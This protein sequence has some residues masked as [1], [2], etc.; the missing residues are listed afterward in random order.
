VDK[1]TQRSVAFG[2]LR[3]RDFALL[4]S[5][6]TVSSLGDGIFTVALA[7]VTLEVD[8]RPSGIAYVFAAR[9][10]PSV[11]LAL[12]G[13][14]V[15]DRISRRLVMLSSDIV[16]ALTVGLI[17]FL[18]ARGELRLWELIVM[19]AVFGGAD[20]FFG[21][22][23]SAIMPDL[24]EEDLLVS[25]NALGQMS[26]QLTTGLIGPA[27]GGVVVAAI[28][29]AWS[30]GFDALTFCVSVATLLMMHTRPER[31][32]RHQSPIQDAREGLRYVVSRRWLLYALLAA[33]L[34]NF[35]GMTPLSVLLPLFVRETLH[36]S[37]LDLGI[38]FA[39]GGAAGIV[40]SYIVARLGRP[41]HIVTATWLAYAASGVGIASIALAHNVAICCICV[42]LEVG[43]MVY[44]DVLFFAMIQIL[45]DREVLG[46]VSSLIY[47]GA[48]S[49]GPFGYLLGGLGASWFGVR[50]AIVLSGVIGGV[51][52]LVC[53]ILPGARDPER[54]GFTSTAVDKSPEGG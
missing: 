20:S 45:V 9:A 53:L 44:G 4:W 30:F 47:L 15:A 28:G 42:A 34:A 27:V 7:I 1:S 19:A 29:N 40:A 3:V 5:G 48:F 10:V 21:P 16:R 11:I 17:A 23:S 37:A 36:A 32:E 52:C 54:E 8:R 49:L 26:S 25:G 46:R 43:L 50:S 38:V 31:R 22:A 6:Q 33:C 51:I 24:L 13:G 39:S 35:F 18:L 12:V 14:V 41:R 2:S